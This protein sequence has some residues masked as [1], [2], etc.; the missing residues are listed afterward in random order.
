MKTPAAG[1]PTRRFCAL[2]LETSRR[3]RLVEPLSS[4]IRRLQ[5]ALS[6]AETE[7]LIWMPPM[8]AETEALNEQ[9]KQSVA[10]LRRHL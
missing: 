2:V 3:R 8:S 10:L 9:I 7:T 6:H 5:P 4:S 1:D